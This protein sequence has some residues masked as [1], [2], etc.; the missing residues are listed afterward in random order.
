M[1]SKKKAPERP[2]EAPRRR[3]RKVAVLVDPPARWTPAGTGPKRL[4][5]GSGR[6]KRLRNPWT[7]DDIVILLKFVVTYQ[8]GKYLIELIKLWME[9]RKAKKIEIRVGDYELK[10][11]GHVSDKALEKKIEQ[12]RELVKGATYDDIEVALPKGARRNIPAKLADKKPKPA[13]RK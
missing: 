10:I 12:F 8:A 11:E 9:Y 6:V 3:A 1:P 7:P 5:G 2:S 4:P 13:G